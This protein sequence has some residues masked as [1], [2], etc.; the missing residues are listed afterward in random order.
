MDQNPTP[1]SQPAPTIAPDTSN[2]VIGEPARKAEKGLAVAALICGIASLVL[3]WVPFLGL[4]LAI[5]GVVLGIIA[6]VKKSNKAM[7]I[8]GLVC[9]GF[10]LPLSVILSIFG[11]FLFGTASIMGGFL[12]LFGEVVDDELTKFTDDPVVYCIE[13]PFS[14]YCEEE[15]D[16]PENHETCAENLDGGDCEYG[17]DEYWEAYCKETPDSIF[18][19]DKDDE[20]GDYSWVEDYVVSI[21]ETL[22]GDDFDPSNSLFSSAIDTITESFTDFIVCANDNGVGIKSAADLDEIVNGDEDELNEKYKLT[23]TQE[24]NILKCEQ[25]LEKAMS[26]LT[27]Q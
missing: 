2:P 9:G 10:G 7:S 15:P 6:L 25:D 18:C 11:T 8:I 19:E 23:L 22:A 27:I 20:E 24:A 4:V 16:D 14:M 3:C 21:F 1:A 26:N 17:S 5:V 13:N 12:N